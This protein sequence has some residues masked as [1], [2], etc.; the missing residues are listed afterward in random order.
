MRSWAKAKC[1]NVD[2]D[3]ET[4]KF[5]DHEYKDPH[6]NW[7]AAWRQ[8]MRRSPEFGVRVNGHA[9]AAP[10]LTW[11]PTEEEEGSNAPE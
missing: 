8:W 4:E 11:R 6:G 5:R 3:V 1:P 9:P 2:I 7:P 10:A